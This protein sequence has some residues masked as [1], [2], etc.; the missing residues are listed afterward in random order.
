MKERFINYTKLYMDL[1]KPHEHGLVASQHISKMKA[2]KHAQ[3]SIR[4][5]LKGVQKAR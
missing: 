2:L 3:M 4:S 1:N 5:L